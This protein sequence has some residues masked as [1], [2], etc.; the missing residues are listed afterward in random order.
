MTLNGIIW[1]NSSDLIKND[2]RITIIT[3]VFNRASTIEQTLTSVRIQTYKNIEYIVID[4][5]STDGTQAIVEKYKDIVTTF[6]SE[7]DKGIYDA[8]NKGISLA[9]GDYIQFLGSDDSLVDGNVIDNIVSEIKKK[10]VDILVGTRYCVFEQLPYKGK[11]FEIIK[12]CSYARDK[13]HFNGRM[14]NHPSMFVKTKL[15]KSRPFNTEFSIAGDYEFFLYYYYR[16]NVSFGF[17]NVAVVFFSVSGISSTAGKKVREENLK[18]WHEYNLQKCIN[19][20]DYEKS[21]SF[22]LKEKLKT[23]AT[24]LPILDRIMF[25]LRMKY[26]GWKVHSCNNPVCRWCGRNNTKNSLNL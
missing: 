12:D 1:N 10:N 18:L 6:V 25:D 16:T 22:V 17:T 19:D 26:K 4:G 2:V 20:I 23:I 13:K 11:Y 8:F 15:L 5:G 24:K 7:S 9:T 21:L 3:A 14:I